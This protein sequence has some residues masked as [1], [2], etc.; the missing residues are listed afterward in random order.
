MIAAKVYTFA[1]RKKK[2][3]ILI[4]FKIS[5]TER[6]IKLKTL[7]ITWPS[8][9]SCSTCLHWHMQKPYRS[10]TYFE[11]FPFF[12]LHFVIRKWDNIKKERISLP[13]WALWVCN[14]AEENEKRFINQHNTRHNIPKEN[15]K[16]QCGS[17]E[18]GFI[19]FHYGRSIIW[20]HRISLILISLGKL[21]KEEQA[22][23]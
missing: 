2:S 15:Y 17:E 13:L 22:C 18:N 3:F 6:I 19:S 14:T 21:Q 12:T 5:F 4:H 11:F 20:T 8:G 1:L 7:N 9:P 23:P 10:G 16:E